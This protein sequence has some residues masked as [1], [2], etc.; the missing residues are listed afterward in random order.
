MIRDLLL[1][2][3]IA[4]FPDRGFQADEPPMI[5]VFPAAHPEVGDVTIYDDGDEATVYIGEIT[6]TH[7]NPYDQSLTD[8]QIAATVTCDV[9]DFLTELFADR[10]LLWT[11][12]ENG[13]GGCQSLDYDGGRPRK[14]DVLT[15]VWSGPTSDY[16]NAG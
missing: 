14:S 3:L 6:H 9:V 13:S 15:Y 16:N 1:P 5:G 8:A 12:L 2:A 7:F 11:S 4:N 10:V